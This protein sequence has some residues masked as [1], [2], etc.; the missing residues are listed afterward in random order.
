MLYFF[1]YHPIKE[2]ACFI[3]SIEQAASLGQG[4]MLVVP[5]AIFKIKVCY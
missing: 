2:A 1:I 4:D 3:V 5:I